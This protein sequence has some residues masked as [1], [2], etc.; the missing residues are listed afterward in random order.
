MTNTASPA[1]DVATG[2][3]QFDAALVACAESARRAAPRL[4]ALSSEQKNAALA[5]IAAALVEHGDSILAANR[6]DMAAA[7]EAGM[8]DSLQDRLRLDQGRIDGIAA[9]VRELIELPDPIG[10]EI[11]RRCRPNGLQIARVRVPLGVCGVIFESRPN[12]AVDVAAIC[13]KSGNATVLRGGSEAIASN[14]ALVEALRDAGKRCGLPDGWVSLVANTDRAIVGDMLRMRSHFDVVIPRGGAGLVEF[15]ASTAVVPVLETGFGVCHTYVHSGADLEKAQRIVVN[16]KTRRP[17]ICN[18]L[19][20]LLV[21][22]EVAPEFLPAVGESLI[23]RGVTMHADPDARALLGLKGGVEPLGPGDL[24]TEWLSLAMSVAVVDGPDSAV[25]H[26]RRHG[27][28]HSEAIVTENE[29]VGHRF[30]REIDAAAVYWNASTQFTDGGEFG[31]GAEV[32]ISTQKL[33]ARGPMGLEELTSYK[34]VVTGA[35]QVR[36]Q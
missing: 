27:S 3:R 14:T 11:D 29:A 33:H 6:R 25:E 13:L 19:D 31:L 17:S 35:G 18:A 10:S 30:L 26:I 20:T 16:A 9:A 5:A 32:G 36:P 12:V 28:G 22:S 8:S 15:V 34:W 4:A 21:D 24:D 2:R 23:G 1:T 7:A